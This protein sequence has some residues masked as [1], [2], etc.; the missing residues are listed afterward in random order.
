MWSP[1]GDWFSRH[2][3]HPPLAEAIGG[4]D[5]WKLA[6]KDLLARLDTPKAGLSSDEAGRRLQGYGPNLTVG[7]QRRNV[8]A[9]I[10]RRLVEPLVA[11]LLAAAAVSGLTGDWPSF[12]IILVIV[13][14]SL[15]LDV[16]Q[17]HRAEAAADALKRSVAIRAD[18]YRDG[19]V[20]SE[21]VEA[22]VPGDLVELKAG[23]LVPADGVVL[24]SQGAHVNEALLT[25]EPYPV[26]KRPGP[27]AGETPADA[28]NG[29]FGGTSVVSGEATMLVVATGATT[30]FGGIAAALQSNEPPS[31]FER[32][33]H[34]FGILIV[35]LT[36]FLVLFVLLTQL[37]YG[38]PAMESFLFAVALAVGLTPELLPMIMTVTL[39]RG[40]VRMA[41]RKVVVKRLSAIHDLGAMDILCTDKT[42]TLTEARITVVAHPG[43]DG[44]DCERV[45]ELAAVN[46]RFETGVRSPLDDAILAHTAEH[47][48]TGWTKL[49]EVPFDFERRRVCVLAE[50]DGKRMA[51][52]KGAPEEILAQCVEVEMN[53]GTV[54]SMD[55]ALRQ[56][57][58][59]LHASRAAEG[60]RL[61]GVAWKRIPSDRAI[62]QPD[63]ESDLVFV[64]YCVFLD[65]PKASAT[66]AIAKLGAAGVRIKIISG[67]AEAVVRHLVEVLRLPAKGLLT[68]AQIGALPD[69]A[70]VARVDNVDLF[71]RIS[72]D[73]KTRIVRAV[74][75]RGHIVGFLGDGINDAPAIR[76]ADVG[77]SV[78]G[79]TDVA[80][81]AADMILLEHDLRVLH[82]GVAEGRRTYAN[83][84]KYVRMGTSSNFG[85]MLSMAAASLFLPFLPLTPVQ[86]LANNLLYD[87][88]ETGIPFD[89]V[90]AEEVA[91]PHSWNM[92]EVLR[93]TL[94]MGPLSSVFDLATF[95]ML[96]LWFDAGV[97]AFRTAWFIESIATQILVIF[98]IRTIKPAWAS[99]VDPV[100]LATSLTALGAALILGLTPLGSVLAFVPLT[101]GIGVGI[102]GLVIAYLGTADIVKPYAIRKRSALP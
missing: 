21:P 84:I 49:A 72:P 92:R 73:Q 65:P 47:P 12:F 10:G 97:E 60:F 88:S 40:A 93:F 89:N 38:R 34:R 90:D 94:V 27:C 37:A 1:A 22:L 25:G 101:L 80:R 81:E 16:F 52:V 31:A 55:A 82:D 13:A 69:T 24:A 83:I 77:L 51:I 45:I 86:V 11:I 74:Q 64:G 9:K 102:F 7:P 87:L 29:L 26:E 39:S 23:D 14:L 54:R 46:S 28:F 36:S 98:I 18:V 91:A 95:A 44:T 4:S 70:L 43:P 2:A 58:D 20:V 35:R 6:N 71:A 53:D 5:F 41:Q 50:R 15:F 56:N 78:D 59:A 99:R 79:A 68:G 3:A 17:E 66:D 30:R 96:R 62:L 42:G 32:G 75:A 85:N 67:D 57:L 61:L 8:L 63:D 100:L 76:A 48:L 19:K 33:I